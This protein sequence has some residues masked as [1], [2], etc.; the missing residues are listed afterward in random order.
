MGSFLVLVCL[1]IL[2]GLGLAAGRGA[3]GIRSM[4]ATFAGTPSP[5]PDAVGSP[6]FR[7]YRGVSIRMPAAQVAEKLGV[8]TQR[9]KAGDYYAVSATESVQISYDSDQTVKS[10]SINLTGDLK[11]APAP[12]DVVGTDIKKDP[13]GMLSKMVSFPKEGFWASYTRTAGKDAT[14]IITLQKLA[15]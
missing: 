1:V 3:V 6:S 5:T 11:T 7:S 4:S 14:V 12:K 10:I 2:S 8:P 15:Q 9:S 13:D